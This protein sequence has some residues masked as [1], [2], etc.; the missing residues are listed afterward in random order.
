MRRSWDGATYGNGRPIQAGS[1]GPKYNYP[2]AE[3][4]ERPA[5]L[6][7]A[8]AQTRVEASLLQQIARERDFRASS[9]VA[10]IALST[11][12]PPHTL[13]IASTGVGKSTA[14]RKIVPQLNI[15]TELT[16]YFVPDH[17]LGEEM[18]ERIRKALPKH[19]RHLVRLHKGRRQEGMCLHAEYGRRARQA[20]KLG[21]SPLE[22]V[23]RDCPLRN[24][25][26]WV[27]QHD[28]TGPGIVILPHSYMLTAR[29]RTMVPGSDK[30]P[31]R[32]VVDESPLGTFLSRDSAKPISIDELRDAFDGLE[33]FRLM[34]ELDDSRRKL[35]DGLLRGAR[36]C[37]GECIA[38]RRHRQPARR[39]ASLP[40]LTCASSSRNAFTR[41][42]IKPSTGDPMPASF[43]R[44]GV[45][46]RRHAPPP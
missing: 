22:N 19:Q 36:P 13:V 25:C 5:S 29:F 12:R 30:A 17:A 37:R 33:D 31:A 2:R 9:S 45:V 41:R 35:I 7:L 15:E 43:S 46:Y 1:K 3:R 40:H 10:A 21:L 27:A 26:A 34:E 38:G 20:E 28:D 44:C 42:R 24:T 18:L 32:F 39:G 8:Q 6:E 4:D 14:V 23:C 11:P 16:Y